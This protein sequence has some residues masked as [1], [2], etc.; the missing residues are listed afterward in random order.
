MSRW[1]NNNKIS[2]NLKKTKSVIFG[3]RYMLRKFSNPKIELEG[4]VL[5]NVGHY[6]YL[7]I[8]LDSTLNFNK[9]MNCLL[10]TV[11]HKLF[12]LSKIRK[13]ITKAAALRSYNV[14]VLPY[15][16]YGDI[17]YAGAT[18]TSLNKLQRLQNR[19]LRIILNDYNSGS[20]HIMHQNLRILPLNNRRCLHFLN[21]AFKRSNQPRY[22]DNRDLLTRA[23]DKKLLLCPKMRTEQMKKSVMYNTAKH[24]NNLTLEEQQA[25][26]YVSFKY[27]A[28][29]ESD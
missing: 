1:C 29:K 28:K 19:A 20:T 10:K 7:G 22:V 23:H 9:H 17:V 14:M 5:E 18:T 15:I 21:F 27:K 13:F 4:I 25:N 24:W 16:D 6:K 11:S 3:T 8:N 2:I 12:L 26:N